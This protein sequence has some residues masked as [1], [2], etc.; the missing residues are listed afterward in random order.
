MTAAPSPQNTTIACIGLGIMG[1]PMTMNLLNAGYRVLIHTRTKNRAVDLIERGA[2]WCDSPQAVIAAGSAGSVEPPLRAIF[3]NVPDTPDVE[4]VVHGEHGEN[5]LLRGVAALSADAARPVIVDHSTI[6]PTATVELGQQCAEHGIAWVDAPVS[7]G[8]V[9]AINGTLSIMVGGEEAA[10]AA[11]RPML[12]VVGG[13]IVHLGPTGSGQLCKACN[14]IAVSCS[15]LGVCEAITLAQRAGLDPQKMIDVV[16]GGAGG[17]WQLANLGPRIVADDFAPGFKIDLMLKDL[18]LVL[19]TA[20]A[21]G[22]TTAG[23]TAATQH[24]QSVQARAASATPS[25]EPVPGGQLGT[26]ALALALRS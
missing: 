13:S 1:H 8:D 12:E 9:G 4:A 3:L 26:Q 15:L 23:T 20:A 6:S 24:F 2:V 16:A 7:G 25:T 18:R 22:L 11:V 14:Q 10:V 19:E 17:S 21:H 5:G